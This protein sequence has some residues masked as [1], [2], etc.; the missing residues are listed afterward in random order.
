MTRKQIIFDAVDTLFFRDS[1]PYNKDE[2]TQTDVVSRFPPSPVT[3]VGAVRAAYARALGWNA[4]DGPDW[5][6]HIKSVLGDGADL[7][8]LSFTGPFVFQNETA[9]FPAPRILLRAGNQ[10]TGSKE[11]MVRL[12]PG[13]PR[14]CDLGN[15]VRLPEPRPNAEG[16]KPLEGWWITPAGL[17]DVLLGKVPSRDELISESDFWG[18]EPRVGISRDACKRTTGEAAIYSPKHIRLRPRVSLA[19]MASGLPDE[20]DQKAMD[21]P[22]PVGGESRLCWLTIRKA[23]YIL[24]ES[25]EVR[26]QGKKVRYAVFVITPAH[27]PRLV[28]KQ[29]INQLPGRLV[30]ACVSRPQMWGGWSSIDRGPQPLRPF[31][32]PGSVLFMEADAGDAARVRQVHSTQIGERTRWGFGLVAIGSWS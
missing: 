13:A 23:S 4:R 11:V 15:Q 1:R 22:Q 12:R 17:A 9:R 3:L 31:I 10:A 32:S 8:R 14:D 30:S 24:P 20:M 26:A 19:M 28:P 29:R 25:P 21:A 6:A 5:P 2:T 7:N 27:L 18:H 16:L